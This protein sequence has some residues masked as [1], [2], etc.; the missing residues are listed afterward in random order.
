[1]LIEYVCFISTIASHVYMYESLS[2]CCAKAHAK[3]TRKNDVAEIR[4]CDKQQQHLCVRQHPIKLTVFYEFV[5]INIHKVGA[6][7][8]CAWFLAAVAHNICEHKAHTNS[9]PNGF[10][11]SRCVLHLAHVNKTHCVVHLGRVFFALDFN[12]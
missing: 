12:A 1:M 2:S 9:D 6:F 4:S 10:D 5:I 8:C 7:Q 11:F 3:N